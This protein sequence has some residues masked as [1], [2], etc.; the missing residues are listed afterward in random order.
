[1]AVVGEMEWVRGIEKNQLKSNQTF[2][3]IVD[4]LNLFKLG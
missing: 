3:M 1:M 2:E 4:K